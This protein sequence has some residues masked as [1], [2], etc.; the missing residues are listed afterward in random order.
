MFVLLF[1]PPRWAGAAGVGQRGSSGRRA[2]EEHPGSARDPRGRLAQAEQ[3]V[4]QTLTSQP[5]CTHCTVRTVTALYVQSLY[6]L[7]CTVR[8][9][10]YILYCTYGHFTYS[11]VRTV[12]VHTGLSL[13]VRY[14]TVRMVTVRTVLSLYVL[15]CH[16]TYWSV[17]VHT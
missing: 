3:V 6:V 2:V 14:C 12:T 16:C 9:V 13:Y 10:L 8:T 7:D 4:G 15:Y 1:P 11:T 5:S 17:T